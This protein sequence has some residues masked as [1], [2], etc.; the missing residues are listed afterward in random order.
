[1][2][3]KT[4]ATETTWAVKLWGGVYYRLYYGKKPRPLSGGG[5]PDNR[6]H[7]NVPTKE[8]KRRFVRPWPK[9]NQPAV[10]AV[11]VGEDNG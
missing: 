11:K 4:E 6:R 9:C 3:E 2:A 7:T 1:M 8:V 10:K 5:W